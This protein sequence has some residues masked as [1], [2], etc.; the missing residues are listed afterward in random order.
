LRVCGGRPHSP[1]PG[2]CGGVEAFK[3]H[4]I[5]G[6]LDVSVGRRDR[7]ASEVG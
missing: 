5:T 3:S 6:F 1:K 2:G 4:Q 7:Q